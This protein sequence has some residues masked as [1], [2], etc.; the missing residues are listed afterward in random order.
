VA[1]GVALS[2]YFWLPAILE[3]KYVVMY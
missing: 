2:A 1:G 3:E